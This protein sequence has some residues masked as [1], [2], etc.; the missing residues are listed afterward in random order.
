MT[1][2]QRE[3]VTRSANLPFS[4]ALAYGDLV[5]IS[6]MVGRNLETGEIA[7]GDI[8]AQTRQT[9]MNIEQQLQKAGSSLSMAL[10]VTIFIMDM[11]LF[12]EMNSVYRSFFNE[13]FPARS[14]VGVASLPDPEALVEIEVIAGRK[15]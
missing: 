2:T 12:K 4:T 5:F 14:C 15:A 10:K 13:D 8:S 9:L 1:E 3:I 11:G 6:G 7:R